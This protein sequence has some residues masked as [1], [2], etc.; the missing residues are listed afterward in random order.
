MSR[1]V[2]PVVLLASVLAGF[3]PAQ[4]GHPLTGT[5]VGDWGPDLSDREHLTVVLSWDGE[6]ISGLINPG[7]GSVTLEEVGLDVTDWT[8][9]LRARDTSEGGAPIEIA[10]EGQM[11]NLESWHRTIRGTW[12]QG[13][14]EGDFLLTRD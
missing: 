7:P 8:V 3:A 2:I 6:R 5:W 11:E 14:R 10:A 12:R 13:G 1:T 4:E 9:R